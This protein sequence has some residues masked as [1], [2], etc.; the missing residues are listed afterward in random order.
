M[1]S[2]V[3]AYDLFSASL[4]IVQLKRRDITVNTQLQ[5]ASMMD[6]INK[7]S[8]LLTVVAERF[9]IFRSLQRVLLSL[10]GRL[11]TNSIPGA[12]VSGRQRCA[13]N[14]FPLNGIGYLEH[15]G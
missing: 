13:W 2:F 14:E 6:A 10:S 5:L 4:T 3:D 11:M 1:G 15:G 7:C 8:A 12:Q 9:S